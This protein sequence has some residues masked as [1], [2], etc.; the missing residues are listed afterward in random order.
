LQ[1]GKPHQTTFT[2]IALHAGLLS[3]PHVVVSPLASNSAVPLSAETFMVN[4]AQQVEVLPV[5]GR[6]TFVVGAMGS[7]PPSSAGGRGGEKRFVEVA[8]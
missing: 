1:E 4:A 6:A 3:L 7:T 8:G 5:S 2:L